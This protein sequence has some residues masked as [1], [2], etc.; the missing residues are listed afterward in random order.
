MNFEVPQGHRG[1]A[2]PIDP[3]QLEICLVGRE[4]LHPRIDDQHGHRVLLDDRLGLPLQFG[5]I[6]HLDLDLFLSLPL[7]G[8][9]VVDDED[10]LDRVFLVKKRN[11]IL[12]ERMG[13]RG[14]FDGDFRIRTLLLLDRLPEAG[15]FL[16]R[17]F[18][19]SEAPA[20]HLVHRD[21]AH[22][23]ISSVCHSYFELRIDDQ[24]G[25]RVLLDDHIGSLQKRSGLFKPAPEGLLLLL[26][27]LKQRVD[28]CCQRP[29]FLL[30]AGKV[31]LCGTVAVK[32]RMECSLDRLGEYHRSLFLCLSSRSRHNRSGK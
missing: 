24:H 18:E 6:L 13:A 4:D 23:G 11:A 25:H 10:A 2:R 28:R 29:E 15:T 9:I 22:L 30:N 21:P 32:P 3:G 26:L 27:L 5:N 8:E 7:F 17:Y 12:L 19:V 16:R 20:E 14:Q 31:D 1:D